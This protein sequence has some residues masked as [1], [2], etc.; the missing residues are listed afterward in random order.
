MGTGIAAGRTEQLKEQILSAIS[1]RLK[2]PKFIANSFFSILF[3][4]SFNL[5]SGLGA[6]GFL[7]F[8]FSS[9]MVLLLVEPEIL[10]YLHRFRKLT[11]KKNTN[12]IKTSEKKK[13]KIPGSPDILASVQ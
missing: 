8:S 4:L 1:I 5:P 13:K 10:L 12:Y 2:N 11:L 3:M 7:F 6:S 9:E